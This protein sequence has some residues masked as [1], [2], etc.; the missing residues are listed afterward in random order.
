MAKTI[1]ISKEQ[2]KEIKE[3][4]RSIKN[5][6]T[7][8]RLHAVQ[9]RG[10]G[11]TNSEIATKLD[12][13]AKVVSRWVSSFDKNGIQALMGG[14]FGGNRRNISLEEETEFLAEYKEQAAQGQIVEVGII[15]AAY[16][17]KV[18]HTIGNNQIYRVLHRHGWRKI[19]P[20]SKHPNKASDEDIEASKKLTLG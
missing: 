14:K 4:R 3:V 20:R 18:G 1:I 17:K 6:K 13:A 2:A 11:M 9:L 8:K 15:K 19:M 12:C 7:D 10:E 5:K 16:V